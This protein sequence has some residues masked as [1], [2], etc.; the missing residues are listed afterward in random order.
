MNL[1][2]IWLIHSGDHSDDR[3]DIIRGSHVAETMRVRYTPGESRSG[4]TYTFVLTRSGVRRYIGNLFQALQMDLDPWEKVQISPV[5][6]PSILFHVGDL[7]SAEDVI[8][9]TVDSLLYTDVTP[10]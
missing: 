4:T 7:G 6:G 5:I 2:S 3:I 8:M 10:E 9:D 1:L